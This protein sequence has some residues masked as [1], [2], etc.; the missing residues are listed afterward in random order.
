MNS[1]KGKSICIF[2]AK[3]GVGKTVTAVNLAGVFSRLQ[4]KVVIIDFDLTGGGVAAY[5]NKP[6]EKNSYNFVEDYANNHYQSLKSYVT[7][8]DDDIDFLA[9]PKD[10]RQGTRISASY[11]EVI[12]EKA[13]NEYDIVIVDTNHTLSEF[14]VTLLDKCDEVLLVVSNDMLDL[15]NAR[16]LIHIFKD[17]E[18]TNYKVMLNNSV[19]PSKKYYSLYDVKSMIKAN[20]DYLIDSSFFLKTMDQYISDGVI[21]TKEAKMPKVYPKV[22]RAFLT[23]CNDLMELE[24]E[25]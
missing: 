9:S 19:H 16:N 1:V 8:F 5:L 13:T 25:K 3:G 10:P 15:K 14:N 22:Y 12:L 4:K 17:A 6:F 23:I 11:I 20:I 2:S 24:H 7:K 21:L 18:K